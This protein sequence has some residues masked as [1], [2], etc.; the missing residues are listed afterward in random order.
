MAGSVYLTRTGLNAYAATPEERRQRGD[1]VLR[2]LASGEIKPHIDSTF[3]LEDAAKAHR[4]IESR[5]TIGKILL[6]PQQRK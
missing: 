4:A 2:W 3:V 5:G 6:L 1:D